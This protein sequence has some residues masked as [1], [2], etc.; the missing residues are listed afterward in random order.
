MFGVNQL[1]NGN[2][3]GWRAG[4]TP[5]AAGHPMPVQTSVRAATKQSKLAGS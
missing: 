2:R 4:P 3:N 5:E 1:G